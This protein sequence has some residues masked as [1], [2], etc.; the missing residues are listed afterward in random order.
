VH[1]FTFPP[2]GGL[3]A[4]LYT[5]P[6]TKFDV[7]LEPYSWTGRFDIGPKSLYVDSALGGRGRLFAGQMMDQRG[8]RSTPYELLQGTT[9]IQRGELPGDSNSLPLIRFTPGRYT[10][11]LQGPA[12]SLAGQP[13]ATTVKATFDSDATDPN[14][15]T[16]THFRI[17]V[18]G[19]PSKAFCIGEKA[20]IRFRVADDVGVRDVKLAFRIG[21]QGLWLPW[22]LGR[23]GDDIV[24]R[25][26]L[27]AGTSPNLCANGAT[28]PVPISVRIQAMDTHGNVLDTEMAPAYARRLPIG[29][30][31]PFGVDTP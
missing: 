15:P 7:G 8:V 6:Q 17:L 21:K 3:P 26:P 4:S 10:L 2:G 14:P 16:L 1:S 20:E 27:G 25:L 30:A 24:A 28:L 9:T 18:D 22:L 23:D 13:T 12:G 19:K 11:K 29:R 31:M 5:T